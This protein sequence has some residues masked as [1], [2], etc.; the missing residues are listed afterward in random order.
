MTDSIPA[1]AREHA[2][3]VLQPLLAMLSR[4]GLPE[5]SNTAV[6]FR[7]PEEIE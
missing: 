2:E 6:V 7:V 4:L 3:A 5:G 1:D